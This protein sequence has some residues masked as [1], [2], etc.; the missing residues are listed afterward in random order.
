M[1][2]GENGDGCVVQSGPEPGQEAREADTARSDGKRRGKTQLPDIEKAEPVA[3]A[4]GPVDFA[5]ERGRSPRARKGCAEF[6]PDQA[7]GHGD[8]RAQQPRADG[9]P[10]AG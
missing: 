2:S 9:K 8:A 4:V 7:V 10:V 6:S 3:G 5:Q 1:E